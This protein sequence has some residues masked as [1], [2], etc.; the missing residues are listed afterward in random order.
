MHGDEQ[1][2]IGCDK[3]RLSVIDEA[4]LVIQEGDYDSREHRVITRLL[5]FVALYASVQTIHD[6][7]DLVA[8]MRVPDLRLMLPQSAFKGYDA[9]RATYMAMTS[10][11]TNEFGNTK[12]EKTDDV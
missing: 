9:L 7:E 5:R 2:C 6:Q 3:W 8:R 11:C 1:I 12:C 4:Y 10:R